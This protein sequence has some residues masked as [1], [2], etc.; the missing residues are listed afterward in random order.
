MKN[1]ITVI[2]CWL[3]MQVAVQGQLKKVVVMGSSSAYGYFPGTSIPRDS[4]W[5]PKVS[6]HYKALGVLDTLYNI[7]T[8]G[9]DCYIGMPTGYVP[10]AGRYPPDPQFNITRAVS[11]NPDVI[12]INFP[13]NNYTFLTTSEIMFCLQ[14]MKDYANAL[15]IHVFISTTQPRDDYFNLVDRQK[16]KEIRDSTM[17]RFGVFA[18]DFWTPLVNEATLF[19]KPEYALGDLVHLNPLG[20]TQLKN[21]V[22]MKDIFMAPVATGLT[23]WEGHALR[24]GVQLNWRLQQPDGTERLEVEKQNLNGVFESIGNGYTQSNGVGSFI[25]YAPDYGNN[26]YRLKVYNHEILQFTSSVV[27]VRFTGTNLQNIKVYPNP[28]QHNTS[29]IFPEFDRPAVLRLVDARGTLMRT[30]QLQPNV[31][32]LDMDLTACPAGVYYLKW[33]GRTG[34]T[35][36]IIRN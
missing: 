36:T 12:L 6:A 29:V 25:D 23:G 1:W 13:S 4:A 2:G 31:Q 27:S 14:T 24:E 19:M 8:P 10:P 3:C 33:T 26:F 16:L 34:Q 22:V 11:F 5:A 20:H 28:V 30:I 15:G 18:M 7:G 9:I 21:V 35:V 17:A 32:R